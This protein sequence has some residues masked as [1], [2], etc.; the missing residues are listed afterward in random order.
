MDLPTIRDTPSPRGAWLVTSL[1]FAF[2]LINFADKAVLGLAVKPIMHDLGLSAAQYGLL[3]SSFYLLFSISAVAVGFIA[4]RVA[5]KW[6]LLGM[7][8]IWAL[9][10]RRCSAPCPS[11]HCSP[12]GSCSGPRKVRRTR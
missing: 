6:L 1:L 12:A 9:T 11:G 7:G 10:R 3:A 4:N 2:M 5:S 8:V